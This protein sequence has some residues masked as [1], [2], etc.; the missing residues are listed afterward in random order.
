MVPDR[1]VQEPSKRVAGCS[2]TVRGS[3]S[4]RAAANCCSDA[5][6]KSVKANLRRGS[7]MGL[8]VL[9]YVNTLDAGV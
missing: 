6:Y 4:G 7:R 8:L 3:N 2:G 5:M 9:T 1:Q